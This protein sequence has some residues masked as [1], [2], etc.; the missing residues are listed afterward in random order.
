LARTIINAY[1]TYSFRDKDPAIDKLRTAIKDSGESY[2]EI[3]ARSG[4]SA[5]TL[6]GWFNGATRRPQFATLAAAAG[7]LGMEWHLR[8]KPQR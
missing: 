6:N 5:T 4:L 1:K 7:A 8:K 3:A 2:S